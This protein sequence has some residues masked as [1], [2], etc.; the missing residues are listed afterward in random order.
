MQPDTQTVENQ[1]VIVA[2][3]ELQDI[4]FDFDSGYR[5][6][7]GYMAKDHDNWDLRAEYTR[8]QN[9]ACRTD[10]E[11]CP[12]PCPLPT[13]IPIEYGYDFASF[14]SSSA[15]NTVLSSTRWKVDYDNVDLTLGRY[16]FVSRYVAFRP[17][18][19]GKASWIDQKKSVDLHRAAAL[20]AAQVVDVVYTNSILDVVFGEIADTTLCIDDAKNDFWGVGPMIGI[21][22]K[23]FLGS[24]LNLYALASGAALFGRF[25]V[26][27]TVCVGAT[28]QNLFFDIV[29]CSGQFSQYCEYADLLSPDFSQCITQCFKYDTFEIVPTMRLGVGLAYDH[30]IRNQKNFISIRAGYEVQYYW[31]QNY[32]GS[33]TVLLAPQSADFNESAVFFLGGNSGGQT[34][35]GLDII[36]AAQEQKQPLINANSPSDLAFHGLVVGA[37]LGF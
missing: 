18:F 23:W 2:E 20:D 17:H 8:F 30:P 29:Q 28:G 22:G 6:G 21:E 26:R 13:M 19:G 34:L 5:V 25:N 14:V 4:K 32:L 3:I 16:F 27:E 35:A 33:P 10:C 12:V 15:E 24:G 7:I 11:C 9:D 31:R 1:T 37:A 36:D